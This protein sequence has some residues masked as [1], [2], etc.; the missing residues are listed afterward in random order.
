MNAD[1][2]EDQ[3]RLGRVRLV[4]FQ[5]LADGLVRLALRIVRRAG[6][7][8]S[9]VHRALTPIGTD[10]EHVVRVRLTRFLALKRPGPLLQTLHQIR[11]RLALG[12]DDDL[13]LALRPLDDRRAV[14]VDHAVGTL[15]VHHLSGHLRQFGDVRE[16][17][18]ATHGLVLAADRELHLRLDVAE[19]RR[20]RIE[21]LDP[22]FLQLL[23]LQV[24]LHSVQ[25]RHRVRDRRA[26]GEDDAAAVVLV[27]QP[28]RPHEHR[29]GTIRTRIRHALQTFLPRVHWQTL[30]LVSLIHEDLVDARVL[31]EHGVV[32]LRGVERLFQSRLEFRLRLLQL[33]DDAVALL[34]VILFRRQDGRLDLLQLLADVRLDGFGF[35]L[36]QVEVIVRE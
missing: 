36:E 14:L 12:S 9:H 23:R 30:E 21:R 19:H 17:C 32:L 11:H 3:L 13:I 28:A 6:V 34:R 24:L 8:Q 16:A 2:R 26:R 18:K 5:H 22:A 7:E 33:L 25:F 35:H 10:D 27:L 29:R 1:V 20:P 15:D 31:E 4:Q